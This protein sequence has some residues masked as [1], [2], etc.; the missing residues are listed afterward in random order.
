MTADT[1][2]AAESARE[3]G[4]IRVPEQW[5]RTFFG[6]DY[7]LLYGAE[8][9]PSR[10]AMQVECV[11]RA[12]GLRP[13]ER[14]LDLCCGFGR[15]LRW[16]RERGMR[17]VGVDASAVQLRLARGP[18]ASPGALRLVRGDVRMLPLGASFDA[19]LCMY[20]SMGY[21]S[22]TDNQ[23]HM[24]EVAR[25]LRPEGRLLIDNQNPAQIVSRLQPDRR[26]VDAA[27]ALTI[28]EQFEYDP[29]ARRVRS[30]KEVSTPEGRREYCFALREYGVDEL[31]AL[32]GQ[33]GL[34]VEATFGD[35]DLR[36]YTEDAKRLIVRARKPLTH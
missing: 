1:G 30:R 9:S 29:T 20:T 11:V 33:C 15:H 36:P 32:L 10:S 5:W 28:V 34:C 31:A 7:V 12:L 22:D 27:S 19:A 17:A 6:E 14:V 26:T 25:V 18:R 21:F 13:G 16:L 4:R 8:L 23:R 2:S 3:P 24:R 35:Y